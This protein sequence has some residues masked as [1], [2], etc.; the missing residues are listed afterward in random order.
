[1][2]ALILGICSTIEYYQNIKLIEND[3]INQFKM[4]TFNTYVIMGA[5]IL[6]TAI[7][8]LNFLLKFFT[9]ISMS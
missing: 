3:K 6:L 4:L 5:L 9:L 7:K 2:I 1:M 8:L